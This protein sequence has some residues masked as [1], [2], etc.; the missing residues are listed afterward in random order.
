M[1][2]KKVRLTI[3][4]AYLVL[5]VALIPVAVEHN[6]WREFAANQFVLLFSA[7]VAWLLI[8]REKN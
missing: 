2:L 1:S 7:A 8:G 6:L 4:L 3:V 5:T